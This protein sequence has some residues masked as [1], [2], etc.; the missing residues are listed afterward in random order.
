MTAVAVKVNV[1]AAAAKVAA[2]AAVHAM[3]RRQSRDE[4]DITICTRYQN[5]SATEANR[6][7]EAATC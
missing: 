4:S 6:A 2:G 7:S 5:N 3:R 1:T